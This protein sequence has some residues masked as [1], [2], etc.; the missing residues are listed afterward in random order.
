[1]DGEEVG[2][3]DGE[4]VGDVDGEEDGLGAHRPGLTRRHHQWLMD[5]QRLM[6]LPPTLMNQ[7]GKTYK[8]K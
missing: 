1:M 8:Q 6:D 7:P 2:D 4:E 3:V 5:L